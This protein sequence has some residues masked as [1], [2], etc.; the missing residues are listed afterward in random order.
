MDRE[1]VMY[2][3]TIGC[4]FV[5]IAKRVL[6]ECGVPY[7]EVFID[8]DPVARDRVR[9]W[10]GFL[11]VP[12]LVV[13]YP[14]GLMPISAPVPLPA[15]TSPQGINRGSMITEPRDQQL[16]DWLQQNGLIAP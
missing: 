1:L 14:G 8:Q 16:L 11:S 9:E 15:N 6:G 4:P 10:T 3:R 2:T 12:T 5:S 7:R 13:V